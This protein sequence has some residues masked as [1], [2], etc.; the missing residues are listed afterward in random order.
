MFYDV[1]V[2]LRTIS[3]PKFYPFL[4][5]IKERTVYHIIMAA[6]AL[7]PRNRSGILINKKVKLILLSF[8]DRFLNFKENIGSSDTNRNEK[9]KIKSSII[10]TLLFANKKSF[11]PAMSDP[12]KKAFAGVGIPMKEEVCRVSILNLANRRAEKMAMKNAK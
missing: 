9:I 10:K 7:I 4:Q 3:M 2:F 11:P 6:N 12:Q 5:T 1:I 8:Q